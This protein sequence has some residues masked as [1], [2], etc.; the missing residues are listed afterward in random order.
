M[1]FTQKLKISVN[2]QKFAQSWLEE[3]FRSESGSI[4]VFDIFN[5]FHALRALKLKKCTQKLKISV[6]TQKFAQSSLEERFGCESGRI[7][8]F[9]IFNSFHALRAKNLRNSLKY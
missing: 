6:N 4:Q 7:Q 2:T 8:V 9:Y 1:K 3:R 5:S